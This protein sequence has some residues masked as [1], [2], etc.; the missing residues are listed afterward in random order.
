M[1][2]P[3]DTVIPSSNSFSKFQDGAN[4]FRILSDIQ[5]GWEGWK[6][7]D[8]FRH[9]GSKC[10]ITSEMVTKNQ[11]G[12][13]NINYFWVAIAYDYQ[14]KALKVLEIT[15]KTI[16]G[17]LQDLEENP[18]WGDL[19]NYDVVITK[20][21]V[22]EKV[23]YTTVANPPKPLALEIQQLLKDGQQQ[24]EDTIEKMFNFTPETSVA[25][26]VL[27]TDDDVNPA[28]IPF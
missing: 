5:I 7:K 24:L 19:K 21:K 1:A 22:G 20:G 27:M 9:K 23:S 10:H 3:K 8:V 18:E 15:Q 13:D 17:A 6:N 16:M 26:K 4:R 25:E 28:D 2:I 12:K 11:D 14:N